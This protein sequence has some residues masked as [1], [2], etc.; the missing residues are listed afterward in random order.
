MLRKEYH[1]KEYI[2][3]LAEVEST[4]PDGKR[5]VHEKA[6]KTFYTLIGDYTYNSGHLNELGRKLAAQRLLLLLAGLSE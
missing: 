5:Q 2:F 4:F 6:G 3:D 1:G